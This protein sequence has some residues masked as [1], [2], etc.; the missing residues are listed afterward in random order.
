[1]LK[2]L[3]PLLD[4]TTAAIM[5]TNPNTLGLYEQNILKYQN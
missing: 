5:M 1:M 3:K 4:N 2:A